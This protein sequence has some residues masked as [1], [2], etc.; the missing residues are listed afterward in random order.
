MT[1]WRGIR[2]QNS[3]RKII[4]NLGAFYAVSIGEG[5]KNAHKNNNMKKT[6]ITLLAVGAI[7]TGFA[8]A[9]DGHRERGERGGR[10]HGMHGHNALDNMTENLKLT[11]EQQ[12]KVQPII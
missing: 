6:L 7:G 5:R 1:V 10:G 4:C 9:N 8:V 3:P 11:P 12:A 2:L